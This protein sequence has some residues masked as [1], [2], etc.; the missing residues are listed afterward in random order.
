[1]EIHSA[2]LR[3][4]RLTSTRVYYFTERACPPRR[5]RFISIL[6]PS[7]FLVPRLFFISVSNSKFLFSSL[8][9]PE[10]QLPRNTIRQAFLCH[11]KFHPS[12]HLGFPWRT[13]VIHFFRTLRCVH[14]RR[15]AILEHPILH[16]THLHLE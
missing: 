16:S 11:C 10:Y 7:Y 15:N 13:R 12:G 8:Q 9:F 2:S 1:M 14:P 5:A 6:F 3:E 4:I